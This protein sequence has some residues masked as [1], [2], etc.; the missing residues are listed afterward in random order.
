MERA[1]ILKPMKDSA[2]LLF[3]HLTPALDPAALG[4]W[5]K[6]ANNP[7]FLSLLKRNP[8]SADE[9]YTPLAPIL[10][11]DPTKMDVQGLFKSKVLTQVSCTF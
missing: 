11:Q 9:P 10:F 1:N 2:G 4:D 8:Q 7:T 3:A 6:R 5:R